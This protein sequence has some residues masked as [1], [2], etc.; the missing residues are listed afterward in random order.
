MRADQTDGDN[1]RKAMA[2]REWARF[3]PGRIAYEMLFTDTD[4]VANND[5]APVRTFLG[6]KA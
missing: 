1:G 2:V 5:F 4:T 3:N 6:N